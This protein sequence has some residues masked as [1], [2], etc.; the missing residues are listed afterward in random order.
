MMYTRHSTHL[1]TRIR[2]LSLLTMLLV[3][4]VF[5][6]LSIQG[7]SA[8]T[9]TVTNTN[10][11]GAG[12]LRQAIANAASGD[13]IVFDSGLTGGTITLTSSQLTINKRL[14]ISGLGAGNLTISGNHKYRVFSVGTS[15]LVTI[16]G[17]T[18]AGGYVSNARGGGI[19]NAGSL[20]LQN[21]IVSGNQI[22]GALLGILAWGGSGIYNSGTLTVTYSTISDNSDKSNSGGGGGIY[23]DGKLILEDSIVRG[24]QVHTTSFYG[25]YGGGGICNRGTA[26]IA[27][28]TIISNTAAGY[29]SGGGGGIYNSGTLTLA[30]S[31]VSTNNA[32]PDTRGSYGGY[33]GG[34]LNW[35][36]GTLVVEGSTI[37][38]NVA[39]RDGGGIINVGALTIIASTISGNL[40]KANRPTSG[41]GQV[42]LGGG[43]IENSTGILTVENSTI[44]NNR[45]NQYAGGLV[46]DEGTLRLTFST[47]S[48]NSAGTIGGG[49]Y[50]TGSVTDTLV[51]LSNSIIANSTGQ[52]CVNEGGAITNT[53]TLIQ[54][55][56]CNPNLSGDPLLGPLQN[57]GGDTETQ[58]LQPGSPAIDQIPYDM[59]GCGTT[60]TTD[61]RDVS[62]P[63]GDNCD[64]GAF[65]AQ[66]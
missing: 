14:T 25:Q 56:T 66:P 29:S 61:Q 12:S 22:A 20:T 40:A 65:E 37:A 39:D 3:G 58:A 7:I 1:L 27:R 44:S 50:I 57:N 49:L 30:D 15:A 45:S 46:N 16:S 33:G 9:I 63:Q 2:Q 21:S 43:G 26:T 41:S 17:L 52:D 51:Y 11:S 60:Y 23:S 4:M 28:S 24:N 48:N 13:T 55:N 64:I 59:N 54:D 8:A 10:D 35:Q 62:R 38:G 5:G 18:I 31:V 53:Y 36:S 32:N 42:G 34:I 19:S 6:P 47:V